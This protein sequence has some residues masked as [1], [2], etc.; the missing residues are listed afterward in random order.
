MNNMEGKIR[1]ID[2]TEDTVVISSKDNFDLN[3]TGSYKLANHK[4]VKENKL[5]QKFKSSLLG[6]DIGISSG[7]FTNVAI[8]AVVVA[9]AVIAIMYFSWRF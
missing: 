2:G 3:M 8:L 5:T 7:G 9:L 1:N 6:S 4:E